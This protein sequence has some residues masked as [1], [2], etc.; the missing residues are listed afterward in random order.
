L[1]RFTS[2]WPP[3]A[4]S[5]LFS[6]TSSVSFSFTSPHASNAPKSTANAHKELRLGGPAHADG[7]DGFETPSHPGRASL[8]APDIAPLWRLR[9]APLR[10]RADRATLP[11]WSVPRLRRNG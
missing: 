10:R 2:T 6:T 8:T 3:P 4:C 1:P 11:A 9:V 7:I 5:T